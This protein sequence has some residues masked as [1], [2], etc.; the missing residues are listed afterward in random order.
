MEHSFRDWIAENTCEE[1]QELIKEILEFGLCD[2]K[3]HQF[4]FHMYLVNRLSR[5][6][7][8]DFKTLHHET[9]YILKY[10]DTPYSLIFFA[11]FTVSLKIYGGENIKDLVEELMA[12]SGD[13]YPYIQEG[14]ER[15]EK[16]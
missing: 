9:A 10:N 4:F 15:S 7:A 11:V 6:L 2:K 16:R 8:I 13:T 3:S 5:D 1:N 14:R 12:L